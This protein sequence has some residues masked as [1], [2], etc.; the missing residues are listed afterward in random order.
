MHSCSPDPYDKDVTS[1]KAKQE[2]KRCATEL[3]AVGLEIHSTAQTIINASTNNKT[4]IVA[5]ALREFVE[6]FG[7]YIDFK[8][9]DQK[10]IIPTLCIKEGKEEKWR[11]F[12]AWEQLGLTGISYKFNSY[13]YFLKRLVCS[14]Q[15]IQMLKSKNIIV[16][17]EDFGISAQKLLALFQIITAGAENMDNRYSAMCTQLNAVKQHGVPVTGWW[18]MKW[19]HSQRLL[20]LLGPRIRYTIKILFRLL[21]SKYIRDTWML[22]KV[23]AATFLLHYYSDHLHIENHYAPAGH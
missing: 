12:I 23:G 3:Q 14:V 13:A 16:A 7:F 17:D 1:M 19:H 22:L 21:F 11:N 8:Q 10:L 6:S 18:T 5:S 20:E 9:R 2:L 4:G 15:D